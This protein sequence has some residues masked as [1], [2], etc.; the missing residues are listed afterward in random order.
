MAEGHPFAL[1]DLV[2]ITKGLSYQGKFLTEDGLPL[3]NLKC[4][5][6]GGGFRR[7]GVKPYS[8]PYKERHAVRPGDLILANTDLT[9]D[10]G[11]IG[12]PAI[13]PDL[14]VGDG[15]GLLSHH[16][17]RV[18]IRDESVLDLSYLYY[19]LRGPSFRSYAQ[20]VASGTTVLGFRT[21]DIEA[22][23]FNLPPM[24]VQRKTA[25]LLGSFDD[26]IANNRR[27][28]EILGEMAQ[29]IYQ[30]WFVHF[31]FPGREG[32]EL[33][34]SDVGPIPEG[35]T[36]VRLEDVATFIGGS[37]VTKASYI[38]EGYPAYSAAGQDGCLS[39]Y[40]ID[41]H[42]VVLSAVGARC[43]RT[44]RASGKWS[45]IANTIKIIPKDERYSAWLYLST[46]EP[47]RWPKRGSAQPF[48][49][50]NDARSVPVVLPPLTTVEAFEGLCRPV[51]DL[52][53][54]LAL[55]NDV[56]T[57]ARDLLLPRLI[58]GELEI[59][60]LGLALEPVA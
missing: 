52:I 46:D 43:G 56:L 31:R 6:R 58:F 34:E 29:L 9:Q 55:Q 40:E 38:D 44:F 20:G 48:V 21:D 22:F 23:T 14:G 49:S 5:E 50:I 17:T 54:N 51:Y 30:E 1:G 33:A 27:R 59:S 57:N 53:D 15:F 11:I 41:G 37:S 26:L 60:D 24:G 47:K 2:E 36:V 16:L 18:R 32:V 3:V 25:H 19:M 39:D 42:G 12:C 45:S 13:V 8:G 35:W 7:D 4:I 28:I 10:G